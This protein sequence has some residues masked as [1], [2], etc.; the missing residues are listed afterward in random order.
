MKHALA[1]M[2]GIACGFAHAQPARTIEPASHPLSVPADDEGG[3]KRAAA[4][5]KPSGN[6]VPSPILVDRVARVAPDGSLVL[7]CGNRAAPD[8]RGRPARAGAR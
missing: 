5:A 3:A 1:A 6:E 8:L 2:L 4:A 7:D